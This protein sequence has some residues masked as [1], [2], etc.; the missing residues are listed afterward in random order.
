MFSH[1]T[2][3]Q[4]AGALS[5]IQKGVLESVL[6]Y[7]YINLPQAR[8]FLHSLVLEVFDVSQPLSLALLRLVSSVRLSLTVMKGQSTQGNVIIFPR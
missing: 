7:G 8:I 3:G 4:V 2:P 5:A 6:T 1:Q